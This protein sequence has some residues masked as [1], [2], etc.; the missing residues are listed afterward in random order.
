MLSEGTNSNRTRKSNFMKV[1]V[2][3]TFPVNEYLSEVIEEKV[4]KL[5]NYSD[6]ITEAEVYL[7]IGEKRHRHAED[8][9]AEI[10]LTIPGYTFFAED[11][12]DAFEK[13][14]AGASNKVKRQMLKY[15]EQVTNH[16]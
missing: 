11:H 2:N 14:I 15:K 10:R 9:I 1:Q 7:K 13:A 4:S 3:A 6:Q 8:Q 12:S 16:H 5:A